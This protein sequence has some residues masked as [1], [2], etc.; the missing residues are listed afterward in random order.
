MFTKPL[1]LLKTAV[2]GW[3]GLV[4]FALICDVS[5]FEVSLRS[6]RKSGSVVVCSLEGQPLTGENC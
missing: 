1:S 5:G 6:F 4:C 3:L 2:A